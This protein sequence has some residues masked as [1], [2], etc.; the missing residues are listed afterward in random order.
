VSLQSSCCRLVWARSLALLPPS[1]VAGAPAGLLTGG[2][3]LSAMCS[4]G[5]YTAELVIKNRLGFHIRP[6]QRFAELAQPFRSEVEVQ[7][8]D[9]KASG[10]SIMSLMGLRGRHGV[11]MK[12]TTDGEDAR[13]ALGVLSF[14]VD[15]NFF[16]ED[17]VDFALRPDR[18]I[19]RLA[20][21][22]SCFKSNVFVEL[23]GRK[24]DARDA[25]ELA[26]IDLKPTSAVKF[27]VSGEDA[28]QAQKVLDRLLERRFYVEE[29]MRA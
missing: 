10:K 9:R 11:V 16:V 21:I 24:V 2:F 22:S 28:E 25:N 6:I 20:T 15:N 8:E 5:P 12:I 7:I 19:I 23:D 13:Q 27:S 17:D 14:L 26:R 4:T 3:Q 29:A 1:G 18:H